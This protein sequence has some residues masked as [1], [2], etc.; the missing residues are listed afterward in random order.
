[1]ESRNF[2]NPEIAKYWLKIGSLSRQTIILM[3]MA[4]DGVLSLQ[5]YLEVGYAICIQTIMIDYLVRIL[6]IISVHSIAKTTSTLKSSKLQSANL[7][8]F[9]F[10]IMAS[11]H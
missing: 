9:G 3:R 1:M 7:L 4:M 11:R 10:T 6:E 8:I 5:V 2:I